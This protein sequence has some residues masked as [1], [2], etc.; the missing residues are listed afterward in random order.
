MDRIV[1]P[2][3]RI[4][5]ALRGVASRPAA[6]RPLAVACRL[7]AASSKSAPNRRD[8][9]VLSFHGRGRPA[10]VTFASASRGDDDY[11]DEEEVDDQGGEGFALEPE[12][13][14]VEEERK[15]TLR[16]AMVAEETGGSVRERSLRC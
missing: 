9:A 12:D 1:A 13:E 10:T 5:T 8:S 2:N 6:R 4:S 11:L 7:N 3:A 16:Q 15:V 14:R